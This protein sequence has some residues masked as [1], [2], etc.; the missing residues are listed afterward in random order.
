MR[1]LGVVALAALI[2]FGGVLVFPSAAGAAADGDGDGSVG[3]DVSVT[4]Y[5][6]ADRYET[7]L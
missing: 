3:S 7:S 4:R 1:R 5:G 2:A 6:G